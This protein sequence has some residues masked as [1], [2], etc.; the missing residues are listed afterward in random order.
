MPGKILD[1]FWVNASVQQVSNIGVAKLMWGHIK[2]NSIHQ[3]RVIFL[4]TARGGR[5]RG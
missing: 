1:S 4:M 3:L 2:V 5:Y